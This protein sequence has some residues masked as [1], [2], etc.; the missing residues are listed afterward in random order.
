MP[1]KD[2]QRDL[3]GAKISGRFPFLNGVRAGDH[4]GSITFTFADSSTGTRIDFQAIVSDTQD[5]PENHTY[6]V[7]TTSEDPPS[8]VATVLENAQSRFSGVSLEDFLTYIDELVQDALRRP[9]FEADDDEEVGYGVDETDF[10]EDEVDWDMENEPAFGISR[11]DEKHLLK[12]LRRDLRAVK[13]AGL[14]V[15]CLGKLTGAIIVSV[16]CRIGRLGI[17]EE[18]MKAWNVRA[19]EYLV[20]L[21]R[22]PGTYVHFQEL[23]AL[24]NAKYPAIQFH[25]GLCD[26]Y[27]PTVE[28][29]IR[30]F[31]GNLSLCE[32]GLTG[33]ARLRSLFI[34]QPLDSLLNERFLRIMELRYHLGL[35]WTGAE[36]YIQQNQGRKPDDGALPDDYFEP[37]TWSASA[38]ALFQDDHIDQGHVVDQLSLPLIAMQF[39]LRHFVKCTEF[40]LVCHCKIRDTFEAIKPY[41]CSNSLCLF[42]YMALG[43]GPSLEHEIQFQPSVVDLLI[44]LTYA[45]AVSG[46]LMDFPTGLGLK[47]PGILNMNRLDEIEHH[48]TKLKNKNSSRVPT[49]YS[50][51]LV[52]VTMACRLDKRTHLKPGDWV[53]IFQT[54]TDLKDGPWHCRVETID[55]GTCEVQLSSP[56]VKGQQLT[57]SELLPGPS[58]VKFAAYETNFDDLD[59]NEKGAAVRLLL[60][61]LPNVDKMKAFLADSDSKRLAAWREVISP[62]A[63]DV[64]RWVVASN[65][66]FIL[67]D[68]TTH[69]DHRVTGMESYK[70]F[71]LVQG[72]PDK[73]QRF[74]AAVA[75]NATITKTD[76]PTIFAWHGSPV[77]NW[78]SILREGLHFKEVTNGRAYGDGVYLSN[79]FHTSVGYTREGLDYAW[80]Q[81]N[82]KIRMLVSLNELVNAPAQFKHTNPHYVVTQL[83]WIQP[84]YLF[85]KCQGAGPSDGT[86]NVKH[87]KPSAMYQQ[88]PKYPAQGP[89]KTTIC[90]PISALNSQRR[91][92]L[93]IVSRTDSDLAISASP[94]R[95]KRKLDADKLPTPDSSKNNIVSEEDDVVSVATAFD[96]LQLLLSEDEGEVEERL[97]VKPSK[98]GVKSD[99]EPGTL[100]KESLPLLTP[101]QYATTPATKVLQQHLQATL[102]VQSREP[103]HDLG[104]YI[105]PDFITTVYQWIVE[106]HSFDP[107]LPLAKDLKQANMKSVVLELRFPPGFPMSPPFVRVIRPRFL[108]FTNGG[109]GHVTAG[110]AMC[111]ELLTNS[112]WLPTASIESVLLQVRMAITNTE[113]RPAR[114]ALNRSRT[115]YSVGE[116]VEAYKRACLAHGWQIPEDIQRLSWA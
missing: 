107:K 99:F 18:A 42:Q 105:D 86:A 71:R 73:E 110:G 69:S 54:G 7:F 104:W 43:M 92:S 12:T 4:D 62:A 72:A 23:L 10:D 40:C 106:L 77:W 109:G 75:A 3:I 60:D 37:D 70:Q 87:A 41:V 1:R 108:E 113:P 58:Q 9:G 44:S 28:D 68:D 103:L 53:V 111:M 5:Y 114:L 98:N 35:S 59:V 85:V 95:K 47:V 33:T 100:K 66:S 67:E 102:K 82:L 93:G 83:D 115:D 63:L 78:H 21:I 51:N 48:L 96:D 112:G 27:K 89:N 29:A 80:P 76:Y 74:R 64:L 15:G 79:N 65:R 17:S 97:T 16:S 25:V 11:T 36:L 88:D 101:P 31:Q 45:R 13:N 24:G 32:E 50:G 90:V 55:L 14:K 19:S 39:T 81:S 26:S 94:G 8:R 46:K 116:A 52:P 34:E 22:Y 20:L 84:R 30:A 38:P 61:T 2:F 56:T 91:N 6:F 49:C 57:A